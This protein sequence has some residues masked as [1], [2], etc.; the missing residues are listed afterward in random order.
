LSPALRPQQVRENEIEGSN[1]P[2]SRNSPAPATRTSYRVIF[3]RAG[4]LE[5]NH[6]GFQYRGN[7]KRVQEV[8]VNF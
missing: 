4:H 3:R 8:R 5:C 6:K 2:V 7:C 1:A